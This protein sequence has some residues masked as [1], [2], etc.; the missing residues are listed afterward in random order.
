[1]ILIVD[2]DFLCYYQAYAIQSKGEKL[3]KLS[4]IEFTKKALRTI[5]FFCSK[6]LNNKV[7]SIFFCFD[8]GKS[9]RYKFLENLG[10]VYK[11]RD[12]NNAKRSLPDDFPAYR[13]FLR[14]TLADHKFYTLGAQGCEAD[15]MMHVLC[16]ELVNSEI[17][18]LTGDSDSH[19]KMISTNSKEIFVLDPLIRDGFPLLRTIYQP[20]KTSMPSNDIDDFFASDVATKFID[21]TSNVKVV[22]PIKGLYI[23]V[24]SG[25]GTDTI[26]SAF[27]YQN[28]T[29][30]KTVAKDRAK[31]FHYE[32]TPPPTLDTVINLF[33]SRDKRLELAQQIMSYAKLKAFHKINDFEL[34]LLRNIKC[35]L[36]HDS[37]YE[38][39]LIDSMKEIVSNAIKIPSIGSDLVKIFRNTEF[40]F[41][42]NYYNN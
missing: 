30:F 29:S 14:K 36:L 23:K 16:D 34:G 42:T 33:N 3:E 25:D 26:P 20:V 6:T 8:E 11:D 10:I 21:Q 17:C 7:E 2:G 35:I 1:M 38:Q 41:S 31:S 19:Q 24:I 37:V 15:D 13:K 18:I 5:N 4:Y 9:W 12:K 28:G 39:Q 27:K 22:D 40:D 32:L